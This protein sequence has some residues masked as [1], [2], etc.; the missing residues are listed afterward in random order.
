MRIVTEFCER[1]GSVQIVSNGRCAG[2]MDRVN[3]GKVMKIRR[4]RRVLE[5][6]DVSEGRLK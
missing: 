3:G 4:V 6:G 1:C 5:N 2:C